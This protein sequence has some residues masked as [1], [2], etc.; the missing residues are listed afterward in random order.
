MA[1]LHDLLTKIIKELIRLQTVPVSDRNKN[2]PFPLPRMIGVGDGGSLVVSKEID[3]A[4]SEVADQLLSEYL[5]LS[6]KVMLA[7]WRKTVRASFGPAL[8]VIDLNEPVDQNAKQVLGEIRSSVTKH[9][10]QFGKRENAFGCTLFGNSTVKSFEIGPVHFEPRI[11]WLKRKRSEGDVSKTTRRRI[12][13]IWS[14]KKLRERKTSTDS[15]KERDIIDAVGTCPFVCSV[16]T[17]GLAPD[18]ARERALTTARLALA[19]VAL[20]WITPSRALEGMNLLYDRRVHRQRA[21]TFVPGKT[22]LAGSSLSHMPHGPWLKDGEWET[23]FAQNSCYFGVVSE[24]LNYVVDPARGQSRPDMLNALAQALL[25][26]HEGCRESVTLM[27]IVKFTA[28]L[29]ALACGKGSDGIRRLITA[30]LGLQENDFIRPGGPTMKAVVN[31]I[32]SEGRSRTI[33]GTNPKLGH[34]WSDTKRL[35]EQFA[36]LCLLACIEWAAANPKS[37]DP[38]QFSAATR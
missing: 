38:T 17:I 37:K 15:I 26:F 28:T 24:I 12:E 25:W 31:Q 35:S 8:A 6:S 23:L 1:T 3:D 30:R 21:L 27:G 11:D 29:D 13:H 36:R 7:E 2:D 32:Y 14:G 33:H 5:S 34:D 22:V 9:V 10:G 4:I 16:V 20:L 18:G 19:A